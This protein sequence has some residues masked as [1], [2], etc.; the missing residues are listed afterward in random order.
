ML[1]LTSTVM[2]HT[3]P[4]YFTVLIFQEKSDGLSAVIVKGPDGEPH[5]SPSLIYHILMA[6]QY[7]MNFT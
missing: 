5:L 7:T 2:V 3:H 6:L 1:I 4:R